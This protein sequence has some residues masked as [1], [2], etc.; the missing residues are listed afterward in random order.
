MQISVEKAVT[1]KNDLIASQLRQQFAR[2]KVFCLNVI[3]APGAGKTSLIEKTIEGLGGEL[4][5][6]V[7]EGDPH[8][9]LD[10]DRIMA[11]GARSLQINTLGG[12]HLDASMVQEALAEV[13]L[14]DI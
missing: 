8:T 2:H 10:S 4:E 12:C 3:A 7:I 14:D 5:I 13:D 6:L 1:A 9:S 11:A